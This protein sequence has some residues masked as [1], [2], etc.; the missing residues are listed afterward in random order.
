M[1]TSYC[2]FCFGGYVQ[3]LCQTY[4]YNNFL[5][6]QAMAIDVK[7]ILRMAN[8][9]KSENSKL[10]GSN[11]DSEE[12]M[13][14][15][16]SKINAK[17]NIEPAENVGQ[18]ATNT[19][20]QRPTVLPAKKVM[21]LKKM[22]SQITPDTG[23]ASFQAL[24][25]T[26]I[27]TPVNNIGQGKATV[28]QKQTSETVTNSTE[29]KKIS[30]SNV[31]S[32]PVLNNSA[33]N[34]VP[35]TKISKTPSV[36]L[37]STEQPTPPVNMPCTVPRTNYPVAVRT[38]QT[39]SVEASS[40]VI[41]VKPTEE[42]LKKIRE[43]QEK[44]KQ[45]KDF[46]SKEPKSKKRQK[47][48]SMKKVVNLQPRTDSINKPVSVKRAPPMK[49]PFSL[50]M[51]PPNVTNLGAFKTLL[52]QRRLIIAKA[53]T[54]YNPQLYK[55]PRGEKEIDT[56]GAGKQ[57][58]K[59]Q[60]EGSRGKE[61]ASKEVVND[62]EQEEKQSQ[63]V[64]ASTGS[65]SSKMKDILLRLKETPAYSLLRARF[66]AIFTWPALLSTVYP[67]I[68]ESSCQKNLHDQL[69][70]RTAVLKTK[71]AQLEE[72]ERLSLKERPIYKRKR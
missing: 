51:L 72:A 31:Q 11:K 61:Q 20:V 40:N 26:E 70:S 29:L 43:N 15:L 16:F 13:L 22:P 28:S 46:S 52:L 25:Y 12:K 71:T 23:E 47:Q 67:P 44:T 56:N 36:S 24:Q 65:G 8:S 62:I 63:S 41:L 37:E 42:Q 1:F 7:V 59:V 21:Y 18:I 19:E 48:K 66:Q 32:T 9:K 49:K 14:K 4:T 33:C 39:N 55:I 5:L 54:W 10:F 34:V 60:S 58:S 45:E 50:P 38:L 27:P 2:E 57:L 6:V 30:P 17:N 64:Q 68:L 69:Q 53:G 3:S 35:R